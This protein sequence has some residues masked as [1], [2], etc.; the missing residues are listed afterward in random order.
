MNLL[1]AIYKL[2]SRVITNR[3]SGTMDSNQSKEQAWFRIE[4]ST[5]DH[6]HRANEVTGKGKQHRKPLSLASIDYE[7][8]SIQFK[9]VNAIHQQ[10]G[11]KTFFFKFRKTCIKRV[12][13]H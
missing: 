13:K 12:Q 6:N 9:E 4:Y 1:S 7:K 11:G 8:V 2:C 3:I 10:S 5:T